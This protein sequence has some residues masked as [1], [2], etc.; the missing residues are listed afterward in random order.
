MLSPSQAL[1]IDKQPK[2]P[3]MHWVERCCKNMKAHSESYFRYQGVDLVLHPRRAAMLKYDGRRLVVKHDQRRHKHRGWLQNLTGDIEKAV[4]SIKAGGGEV[5]EPLLGD[6]IREETA[7]R[8]EDNPPTREHWMGW[9]D[10]MELSFLLGAWLHVAGIVRARHEI[11]RNAV[12]DFCPTNDEF[13]L[14]FQATS[15]RALFVVLRKLAEK[16]QKHAEA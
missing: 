16:R 12:I 11:T 15:P 6:V 7:S 2:L 3:L 10:D 4:A 8:A 13:N 1:D 5:P 14:S 9:L